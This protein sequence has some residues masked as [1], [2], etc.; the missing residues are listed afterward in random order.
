MPPPYVLVW[1]LVVFAWI[2]NYLVRMGFPA[3]LPPI[4]QELRLSFTSA[5]LLSTAAF[6]YGYTMMQFPAGLLGDRFGR[7]RVLI[8]GLLAGALASA[9]TG[10]AGAFATLLAARLLTGASQGC[11]FSNDRA[12]IAAVTPPERI[13]LGQAVSF[14]GP[15]LGMTV[16]L[17]LSGVLGELLP[18]RQVFFVFAVP[19]V[20]AA[21]LIRCFVPAPPQA[22]ATGRLRPR[23]RRVL[24]VP[25]V[26][27]LGLAGMAVM[28]VL[29]ALATWAPT[30]FL[31]AGVKELGRAALL[32]S[33]QG[34]AGVAGLVVGGSAGDRAL[35]RRGGRHAVVAAS[36]FA[37]TVSVAALALVVQLWRSPLALAAGLVLTAV[38]A[39]SVW[40]PSFALL[41][42]AF[43]GDDL[44][45][46]F[47]IYNTI[48]VLGAVVAPLVT[49]WMRDVTGSFSAGCY[50]SAAVAAAGAVIV[51]GRRR[52]II[53]P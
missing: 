18:W 44:S 42:E 22:F 41:S 9:A 30:M 37:L 24:A 4:M 5:G 19:P 2:A 36:L 40:G 34:I 51:L 25:D 17:L 50:L 45:T 28:W 14:S 10:L 27:V 47:G 26:W 6:F 20:V 46:A 3:L 49:G 39:W 29:Y 33:L 12:I 15:G 7:R 11:L 38:C 8:A 1:A 53:E 35:G 32:A 31:E 43:R 23:V 48:C 21:L 52:A 16:G 13:A